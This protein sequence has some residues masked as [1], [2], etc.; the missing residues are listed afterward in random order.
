MKNIID[1]IYLHIL[2]NKREF[3]N[4]E[5][6]RE[7]FKIDSTSND[8]AAKIV[9]PLLEPDARF[10]KH[11]GRGWTAVKKITIEQLPVSAARLFCRPALKKDIFLRFLFLRVLIYTTAW[12]FLYAVR[13]SV[14]VLYKYGNT[15]FL[16]QTD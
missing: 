7:F 13:V 16:C 5:L 14:I 1:D 10:S 6:L 9:E 4:Q 8:M 2:E 15:L 11:P 3:S 12:H